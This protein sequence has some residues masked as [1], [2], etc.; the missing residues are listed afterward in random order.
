[1]GRGGDGTRYLPNTVIQIL[2]LVLYTLFMCLKAQVGFETLS[3]KVWTWKSQC[4]ILGMKNLNIKVR[5]CKT[6]WALKSKF[7]GPGL[8]VSV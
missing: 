8:K 3:L 6:V 5:Q 1:M 2:P 7:I 4:Q